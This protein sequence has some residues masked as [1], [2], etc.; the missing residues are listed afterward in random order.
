[1]VLSTTNECSI[2][3]VLPSL[4]GLVFLIIEVPALKRWAIIRGKS[5]KPELAE[6]GSTCLATAVGDRVPPQAGGRIDLRDVNSMRSAK[7]L[8]GVL[9]VLKIA[10]RFNAGETES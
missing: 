7:C 3:T 5:A 8:P 6:M 1:M 9:C 2:K 4:T 10:Q